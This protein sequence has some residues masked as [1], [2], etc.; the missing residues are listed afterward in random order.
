MSFSVV[1]AAVVQV[2]LSYLAMLSA[3]F[4]TLVGADV[5]IYPGA[6]RCVPFRA[7][8]VQ[9]GSSSLAT[10]TMHCCEPDRGVRIGS[11]RTFF[12]DLYSI[13]AVLAVL[14]D[15]NF[16]F[17]DPRQPHGCAIAGT[18]SA[19]STQLVVDRG[20]ASTCAP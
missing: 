15:P 2:V 19:R 17:Q 16:G 20:R 1:V 12:I 3:L 11:R 5:S 18:I 7:V 9:N 14:S 4:T 8:S 10:G 13:G 6:L